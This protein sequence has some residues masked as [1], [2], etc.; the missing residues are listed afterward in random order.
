[1]C[2]KLTIKQE[3][4]FFPALMKVFYT[5]NIDTS[6]QTARGL[7]KPVYAAAI[8]ICAVIS[9]P[10]SKTIT[11]NISLTEVGE[12]LVYVQNAKSSKTRGIILA[13][14]ICQLPDHLYS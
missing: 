3:N 14:M 6:A 10:F 8:G 7:D 1:M 2:I 5:I 12:P 4:I 9:L 13:Y 11:M